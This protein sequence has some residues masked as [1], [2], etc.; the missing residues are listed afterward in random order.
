MLGSVRS[1][2]R[3]LVLAVM[4]ALA[5]A[6]PAP[7]QVPEV[8]DPDLA[9]RAAATG[10]SQPTSIAFLGRHDML[11]LEKASGQVKRIVDGQVRGVVL[12]LAVNS[13]SERG[14]LGIALHPRFRRNGWVYLF[15]SESKTGAD[16]TGL[17]GV[18]LPCGGLTPSFDTLAT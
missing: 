18:M 2:G 17:D 1:R 4:A 10:L 11:V 15:W 16:S 7:A 14:L 6:A 9:V 12:D 13:A 3:A 5:V 8:V